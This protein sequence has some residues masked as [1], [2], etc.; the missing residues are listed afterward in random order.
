MDVLKHLTIVIPTFNRQEF[1][2]RNMSYWQGTPVSVCVLDGSQKPIRR[3]LLSQF[4]ENISYFHLPI[5]YV[6]RIEYVQS[7]LKTRYTVLMGDDEF[8]LP[9]GLATAIAE[10]ETATD[11][12]SCMGRAL[13]FEMFE[14]EVVGYPVYDRLNGYFLDLD[15]DAERMKFHMENYVPSTIYSVMRTEAWKVAWEPIFRKEF[16]AWGQIEVCFELAASF[17]GK[18]RVVPEL[19]WLRSGEV[20]TVRST[21]ISLHGCRFSDWWEDRDRA[22]SHNELLHNLA[23]SL[24]SEHPG[25]IKA[26]LIDAINLFVVFDRKENSY[27]SFEYAKLK[28]LLLLRDYI[29]EALKRFLKKHLITRKN[30]LISEVANLVSSGVHVNT[31]EV[32]NIRRL[33]LSFHQMRRQAYGSMG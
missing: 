28:L 3:E 6:A 13:G 33:L 29:P 8:Y 16:P 24:R 18:S 21:D 4:S 23:L 12:I 22:E 27:R 26:D 7:K 10:L 30:S 2:L 20:S 14:N 11:L 5:S 9:S 32:M 17:L 31:D 25:A 15:D 1:A 19:V